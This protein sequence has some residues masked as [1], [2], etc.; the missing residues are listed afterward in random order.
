MQRTRL[1]NAQYTWPK[2]GP[3]DMRVL[4]FSNPAMR[5]CTAYG[6]QICS[7]KTCH[8]GQSLGWPVTQTK[9]CKKPSIFAAYALLGKSSF[10]LSPLLS[11]F[12][13]RPCCWTCRALRVLPCK[14]QN[15]SV[16]TSAKTYIWSTLE[17]C[18]T[19]PAE[20]R[21]G[22]F[23]VQSSSCKYQTCG[24][25]GE[26]HRSAKLCATWPRCRRLTWKTSL[27]AAGCAAYARMLERNAS[28]ARLR[29]LGS[30]LT[31]STR[32]PCSACAPVCVSSVRPGRPCQAVDQSLTPFSAT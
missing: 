12:S 14:P 29:R 28:L 31:A 3:L 24:G 16:V 4:Y 10:L 5:A 15:D 26:A 13:T 32:R 21:Y 30:S 6:M 9:D 20:N 19:A 11:S 27:S 2:F 22:F 25:R 7:C 8:S 17:F 23:A 18:N 1:T